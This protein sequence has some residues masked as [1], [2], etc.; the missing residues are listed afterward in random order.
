MK[1]KK[2]RALRPGTTLPT[3]RA[4]RELLERTVALKSSLVEYAVRQ[5]RRQLS[6]I[7][8]RSGSHVSESEVIE[9]FLADHRYDDGQSIHDRFVARGR[10]P[11]AERE[12]L[13]GWKESF[14]G[15]FRIDA[16][17]DGV[18]ESFNEVDELTY[19]FVSN[20]PS[21]VDMLRPGDQWLLG[22]LARLR[23]AWQ[24][25]GSGRLIEE[26]PAALFLAA[27][28]RTQRP[29]LAF[30]NP[31]ILEA[32]RD[33]EARAHEAF[34]DAHGEPFVVGSPDEM[35]RL[36]R[37]HLADQRERALEESQAA[38]PP[39]EPES[40][41]FPPGL[42][43]VESVG[44]LHD[45]EEGLMMLANAADVVSYLEGDG[46]DAYVFDALL[47][48]GTVSPAWFR[49][50][51]ERWPSRLEDALRTILGDDTFEWARDG[52]ALLEAHKPD[53][54]DGPVY[55]GHVPVSDRL[56]HALL[57]VRE[58]RAST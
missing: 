37:R 9:Q 45:R 1:R 18:V 50:F 41:H 23:D 6:G 44:L 8:A 5:H 22:R 11:R 13:L 12:I 57:A 56:G 42:L 52:E 55:P 54:F 46:D 33:M 7:F 15:V 32:A 30:R 24:V 10:L 34:V 20:V 26:E 38:E 53:W 2:K 25:S 19:R 43:E 49:Y 4:R 17:E 39:F 21:M 27:N 14:L 29:A 16:I 36:W 31:E 51:A 47:E 3:G 35:L 48:A 58:H 40:V 28:F